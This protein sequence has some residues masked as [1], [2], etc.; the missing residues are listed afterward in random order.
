MNAK[1]LRSF[2]SSC[3]QAAQAPSLFLTGARIKNSEFLAIEDFKDMKNS[4]LRKNREQRTFFRS[5]E[6][7]EHFLIEF[8]VPTGIP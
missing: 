6:V 2:T 7:H 3:S 4:L 1:A 8:V 5:F